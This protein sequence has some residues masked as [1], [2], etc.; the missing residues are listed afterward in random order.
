MG[1]FQWP[2]NRY[3][4]AF[5]FLVDFRDT[6][7][8]EPRKMSALS[9]VVR[10]RRSNL[11]IHPHNLAKIV[12]GAFWWR[13]LWPQ[14]FSSCWRFMIGVVQGSH[15]WNVRYCIGPFY[16]GPNLAPAILRRPEVVAQ[17]S[18]SMS[19]MKENIYK[20]C[21]RRFSKDLEDFSSFSL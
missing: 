14:T 19:K 20:K 15:C 10:G 18:A 17:R 16:A 11:L 5:H 21:F 12:R 2:P 9:G 1:Y 8:D 7:L 6:T 3:M 4:M 13:G